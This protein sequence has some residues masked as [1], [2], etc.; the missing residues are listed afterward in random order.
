MLK[1]KVILY[2][3]MKRLDYEYLSPALTK[4][5]DLHKRI[6]NHFLCSKS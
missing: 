3:T 1:P 2:N 4:L 5:F 6:I